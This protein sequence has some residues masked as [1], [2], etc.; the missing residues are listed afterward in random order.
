MSENLA[1]IYRP[2]VLSDV[3]GNEHLTDPGA[4][5]ANM[6]DAKHCASVI[7]YGP[8]GSGKTTIA[9]IMENNDARE[10][11][12]INA[13]IS[14]STEIKRIE[15]AS[16]P[17]IIHIDEIQCF[18][19]KQQQTLLPLIENEKATLIATTSE[20]PR[21]AIYDAL[22]SRCLVFPIHRPSKDAV[23]AYLSE[24][25]KCNGAQ[26]TKDA[27]EV[28][29][30][31]TEGDM[32]AILNIAQA[33]WPN[34][35]VDNIEKISI[36]ASMQTKDLQRSEELSAFHK[37][38]RGSDPNASIFYAMK[39][40]EDGYMNDLLR[41]MEVIAFEDVGLADVFAAVHTKACVDMAEDLGLPEAYKPITQAVL[42]LACAKKDNSN[43]Q[44]YEPALAD[45]R[46]NLGRKIPRHI[47]YVHP[48]DY[49]Y[50]HDYPNHWVEQQYLPDDLVNRIYFK[51]QRD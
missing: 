16:E 42:Y 9:R 40:I 35:T 17:V 47:A 12:E 10:T 6:V 33:I 13:A 32:R 49:K 45:V 14:S 15:Q 5:I 51:P 39:L 8:P 30:G 2:K 11:I 4:P 25:F 28:L 50:P 44:T 43:E 1:N 48:I 3:I 19:K 18:N 21:K 31:L 24:K 34:I 37:S 46:A 23:Y 27:I 29:Y 26:Y 38:V 22:L 36:G 20:N 7:L 41:R